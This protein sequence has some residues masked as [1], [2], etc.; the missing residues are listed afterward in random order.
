M[1][2]MDA[3]QFCWHYLTIFE[4]WHLHWEIWIG[5]KLTYVIPDDEMSNTP[6]ERDTFRATAMA[7]AFECRT[8]GHD[9]ESL[10]ECLNN[11]SKLICK[12]FFLTQQSTK[13]SLRKKQ[14]CCPADSTVLATEF[15]EWVDVRHGLFGRCWKKIQKG[16]EEEDSSRY[17]FRWD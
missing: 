5:R 13:P 8:T 4:E 14:N 9:K 7:T 3:N 12:E 10:E 16:S 11:S 2:S 15:S 1:F 6:V 17:V